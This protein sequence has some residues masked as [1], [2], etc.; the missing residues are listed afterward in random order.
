MVKGN[1][2]KGFLSLLVQAILIGKENG[3][4]H[5]IYGFR[6][7][8]CDFD[9]HHVPY[10][11]VYDKIVIKTRREWDQKEKKLIQINCKAYNT[12]LCSLSASEFN[13]VSMC[14][15]VKQIWDALEI[16]YEGTNQVKESKI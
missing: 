14:E 8:K 16:T 10:K 11:E 3:N 6:H 7:L 15:S 12:L 1:L 4:V 2:F 9:S 5:S 13:K